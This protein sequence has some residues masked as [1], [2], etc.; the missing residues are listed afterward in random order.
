[1]IDPS[2]PG[3]AGVNNIYHMILSSQDR[4][5][6]FELYEW[7]INKGMIKQLLTVCMHNLIV[8]SHFG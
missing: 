5:F 6:H 7:F 8:Y 1:M 2:K 3:Q 4:A